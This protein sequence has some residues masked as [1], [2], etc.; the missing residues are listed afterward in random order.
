MNKISVIMPIFNGEETIEY[1]IASILNQTYKNLELI[2][3]NDGSTDNSLSICRRYE[4]MDKRVFVIDKN[5]EGQAEARNWG[6]DVAT[7][8]YL[9]FLDADDFI[10]KNTFELMLPI[11]EKT[12][13]DIVEYK[14]QKIYGYDK[15]NSLICSEL[16]KVEYKTIN[17]NQ[18]FEILYKQNDIKFE[19]WNKIIKKDIIDN[20]RFI[21]GPLYEEVQFMRSILLKVQRYTIVNLNLHYYMQDLPGN[22]NSK[23]FDVNRILVYPEFDKWFNLLE[24]M[25][26]FKA[27]NN[28][29]NFFLIFVGAQIKLLLNKQVD[30]VILKKIIN[31]FY[32]LFDLK[33]VLFSD[34]NI[35]TKIKLILFYIFSPIYILLIILK[36][37]VFKIKIENIIIKTKDKF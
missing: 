31:Q 14:S 32:C 17:R 24:S 8:D 20:T 12:D 21:K 34:M 2:L 7:G 26:L 18:V 3:V 23:P 36:N 19:V 33:N 1:S 29:Q 5:N 11:I 22:T 37:R 25:N 9:A 27:R 28:L 13:S 16:D 30:F 4:N 10:H 6:I 15:F 35:S